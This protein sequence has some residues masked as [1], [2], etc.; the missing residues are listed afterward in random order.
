MCVKFFKF[1]KESSEWKECGIGDVCL[2]KYKENGKICLVMCCD[3]I[4]KVCVNYYIV[5]EMKFSFNVGF[6]RS[7]V[8]N[9]VVDVSEGE[10]EVVILVICFVNFESKFF[11]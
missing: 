6:D 1:V 4:F 10:V 2:F 3:K 8:W 9:V 5:F 7:W 11:S